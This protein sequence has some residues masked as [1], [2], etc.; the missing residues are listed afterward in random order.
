MNVNQKLLLFQV[1]H[2]L[3]TDLSC[4]GMRSLKGL[5]ANPRASY[6]PRIQVLSDLHLEV[7]QQYSSFDFPVSAPWLVLAGDIGRLIDYEAY[8]DFIS[9][10]TERY[11]RVF[12]V[13]GNHEFYGLSHQAGI[14]RAR[15]LVVESRLGGKVVLLHRN[16]WDDPELGSDLTILGCTLWS[17]VPDP[18]REIVRYKVQDFKKI[19]GWSPEK[20]TEQHEIDL[21]WLHKRVRELA[22]TAPG[23]HV[24]VVTH[25]APTMKGTSAPRNEDNPWSSAYATHVLQEEGG[26]LWRQ[27]KVW[28]FGH[29]HY[30]TDFMVGGVRLL[31]NQRGYVHLGV[32]ERK[33]GQHEFDPS[34]CIDV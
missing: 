34:F 14:E 11:E 7:G 21:G 12:L 23:R 8:L 5:F 33:I 9:R 19:E 32:G 16:Q 4:F 29:T 30:C 26:G 20:H 25:H 22:I 6:Q 24:L 1:T 17:H 31:A 18:A 28:I 3:S 13:L 27:V 10:Q 2:V 15:E